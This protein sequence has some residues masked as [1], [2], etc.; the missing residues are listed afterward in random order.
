[1]GS[2]LIEIEIEIEKKLVVAITGIVIVIYEDRK[3][4]NGV[5]ANGVTA[6]YVVFR[7]RDALGEF[8]PQ[9]N[10]RVYSFPPIRQNSPLLRRPH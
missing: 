3:E 5:N 10:A 9:Q 1:M 2:T 6:N 7:Q 8:L 4:T